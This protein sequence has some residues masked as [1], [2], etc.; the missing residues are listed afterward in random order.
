MEAATRLGYK[1]PTL[2]NGD[3]TCTICF[4]EVV[5]GADRLSPI[6][7]VERRALDVLPGR[8]LYEGVV[9]LACQARPAGRVVV[10]K[11][12]VRARDA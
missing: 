4:V 10:K 5:E 9:R 6:G 11:T 1:W 3:G 12:G 8:R 7:P 2:C